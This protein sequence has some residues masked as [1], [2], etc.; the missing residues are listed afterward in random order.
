MSV[1]P[2]IHIIADYG[3]GDPAW[4]EVEE[5][6]SESCGPHQVFRR[7]YA[8]PKSTLNTGF[9]L[10]QHA[11][12]HHRE[13]RVFYV[14]TAPRLKD[15]GN[16]GEPLVYFRLR[17]GSH[18][19]AVLSG[20]TLS[21]V[22]SFL[23]S[24]HAVTY[25]R[26]NTPFRSRDNFPEVLTVLVR[27]RLVTGAG[28][29]DL[30]RLGPALDWRDPAV[31]PPLPRWPQVKVAHVDPYGNCKLTIRKSD[32]SCA[33]ETGT[34]LRVSA[35]RRGQPL[36]GEPARAV[37]RNGDFDGAITGVLSLVNGS[38]GFSDPFIELFL[39]APAPSSASTGAAH[40]LGGLIPEDDVAIELA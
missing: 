9:W 3:M 4:V 5:A 16:A 28:H 19:L 23:D 38:S 26:S 11:L 6:I 8:H 35:S 25:H 13:P 29:G 32:L 34:V 10:A 36:T 39:Y 21:F 30:P 2:I 27:A 20:Y 7:T 22:A 15:E 1:N 33:H 24:L 18:G 37:R 12:T 40:M 17:N 31:V 14:N